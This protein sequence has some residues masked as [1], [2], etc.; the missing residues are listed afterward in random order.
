MSLCCSYEP[1]LSGPDEWFGRIDVMQQDNRSAGAKVARIRV[2]EAR[3]I[4][5]GL[6]EGVAPHT[7]HQSG[8]R[9]QQATNSEV[10]KRSLT[11]QWYYELV[12]TRELQWY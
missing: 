2:K 9:S 3:P 12:V 4:G 8:V 7:S 5:D 10:D 11:G 1:C 6:A